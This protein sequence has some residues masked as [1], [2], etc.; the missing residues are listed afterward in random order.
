MEECLFVYQ[1]IHVTRVCEP[2]AI[3]HMN[4]KIGANR[5]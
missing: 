5:G 4:A 2:A 3:N 1:N